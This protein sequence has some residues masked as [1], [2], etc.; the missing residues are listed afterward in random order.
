MECLPCTLFCVH[1]SQQD[2]D[3]TVRSKVQVTAVLQA[4]RDCGCRLLILV[5]VCLLYPPL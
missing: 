2:K 1:E 5:G 3:C 4:M